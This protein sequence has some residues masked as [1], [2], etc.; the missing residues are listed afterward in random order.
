MPTQYVA[1]RNMV[2]KE[3]VCFPGS[4]A[5]MKGFPDSG[6]FTVVNQFFHDAPYPVTYMAG[7][8]IQCHN[9]MQG[10]DGEIGLFSI[11]L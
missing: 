5:G 6:G 4:V 3:E 1:N 10:T 11:S 2:E 9:V 7:D 8:Y